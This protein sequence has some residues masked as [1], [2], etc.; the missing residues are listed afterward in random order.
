MTAPLRAVYKDGYLRLIDPIHLQDNQ[1]VKIVI[2]DEHA[3]V[4]AA[5][6]DLVT[7]APVDPIEIDEATLTEIVEAGF[8]HT[9]LSDIILEERNQGP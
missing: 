1:E 2:L 7:D 5:L 9:T 6:G 4:R 8:F 3:L